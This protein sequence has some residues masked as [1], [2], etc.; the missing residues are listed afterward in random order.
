MSVEYHK[1]DHCG[2]KLNDKVDFSQVEIS[3]H[4][5]GL[6]IETKWS[7]THSLCNECFQKLK[8]SITDFVEAKVDTLPRKTAPVVH[9]HWI[10]TDNGVNGKTADCSACGAHFVYFKGHLQIDK[11]PGCPKCLAKMDEE[12]K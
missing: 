12:V 3:M 2:K 4:H 9:G 1:C 7:I 5:L 6:T 8:D 11:M 10:V